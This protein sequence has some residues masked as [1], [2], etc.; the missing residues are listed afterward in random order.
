VKRVGRCVPGSGLVVEETG[1]LAEEAGFLE[2]EAS[3]LEEEGPVVG[4]V[5]ARGSLANASAR[6]GTAVTRRYG[7][8]HMA[9]ERVR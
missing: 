2:E 6:D 7:R 3:F 8:V 9:R 4:A 1:H 5:D